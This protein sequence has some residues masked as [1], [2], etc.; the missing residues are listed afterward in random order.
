[1][2]WLPS[3]ED[4]KYLSRTSYYYCVYTSPQG[5]TS[6]G[7]LTETRNVHRWRIV[8]RL[9]DV[10]G[11]ATRIRHMW[12]N[13]SRNTKRPLVESVRQAIPVV[14]EHVRMQM[15]DSL[16][17]FSLKVCINPMNVQLS[18]CFGRHKSRT[19]LPSSADTRCVAERVVTQSLRE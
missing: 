6:A 12:N 9:T 13:Q 7:A 5:A 11:L 8:E 17:N 1:M 3:W 18:A 14:I 4:Q 2:F 10:R 15:E 16:R 19:M